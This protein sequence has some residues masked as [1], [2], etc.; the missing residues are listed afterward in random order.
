M[1]SYHLMIWHTN[2]QTCSNEIYRIRLSHHHHHHFHGVIETIRCLVLLWCAQSNWS[3]NTLVTFSF[4]LYACLSACIS[5][6]LVDVRVKRRK[7]VLEVLHT[8]CAITFSRSMNVISF[9]LS[10]CLSI[11]SVH[12]K[13]VCIIYIYTNM[14]KGYITGRNRVIVWTNHFVHNKDTYTYSW[15]HDIG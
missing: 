2:T 14:I 13:Q 8:S 10:V 15:E 4:C 6:L 12:V 1:N 9:C 3:I 5:S 11:W 7:H